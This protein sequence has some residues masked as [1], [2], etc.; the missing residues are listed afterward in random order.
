MN[1]TDALKRMDALDK[2]A[3][4]LRKILEAPDTPPPEDYPDGTPGWFWGRGTD[5]SMKRFGFL[6]RFNWDKPKGV[7]RLC[8]TSP[9]V[10]W[11]SEHT[12]FEPL[13]KSILPAS[14]PHD[15]SGKCPVKKGT[16]VMIQYLDDYC[17]GF[18]TGNAGGRTLQDVTV[19]IVLNGAQWRY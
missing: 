4:E 8:R 7:Y 3:A 5:E 12:N 17:N 18:A 13:T 11:T 10:G 9:S 14:I 19:Y 16:K 1:K 2:E 15:S 6:M